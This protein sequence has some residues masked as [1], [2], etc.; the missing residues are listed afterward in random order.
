VTRPPGRDGIADP[1]PAVA[2]TLSSDQG[3]PT[4]PEGESRSE[5]RGPRSI[6]VGDSLGRYEIG[7]ELGE[8]GMATVFRAR[9]KELRRDV[10]VKVLFPHLARR[11][12]IVR[13]FHREA[14]AAAGLEHANILRIYDVG[15]A[16]GDDPPYIVME[17]IRGRT[18]L[19]EVEQ[20]GAVLAEIVAC[21]GSL[22]ADAL[23]AAHAAGII[24]RDIKPANVL[25]A[26]GGRLLLADFG[27][28]RL[29]TED[30]L[31]TKTGALLGTPAYMSPE[32]AS[33]D[34]A[35]AKS[36]LYSLGATLYQLA[37][38]SLPYT[39][40]AA[41]VMAQIATGSL[42][43]PMRKRPAVG[44]DLSR[45]IERLMTTEPE[46]RPASAATVAA[47]LRGLAAAGALGDPTE[48]LAAYFEDPAGFVLSRTPAIVTGIITAAR[49]AMTEAKYPRAMSLADRA[50]ALAPGDPQVT[51]LIETV[52]EGGRSTRRRRLLAIGALGL[53]AAGGATALGFNLRGS[54]H[55]ADARLVAM[56]DGGIALDAPIGSLID[57][58]DEPASDARVIDAPIMRIKIDAGAPV[59]L[60][61]AAVGGAASTEAGVNL[62]PVDAAV[63]VLAPDAPP[64]AATATIIVTN[65]VWCDIAIDGVAKGRERGKPIIVDAGHHTVTCTQPGINA[66]RQEVDVAAG[67]TRTVAGAML[68]TFDIT[69]DST[70]GA[71]IDGLP[72]SRGSTAKL[73]AGRHRIKVGGTEKD[74][75]IFAPCKIQENPQLDCY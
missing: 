7:D 45:I 6:R 40:P 30:S 9:D 60:R 15:G 73:K 57:A 19:E 2:D 46:Q 74:L 50:S 58:A 67:A 64:P 4:P 27:V 44:P 24:H 8:G 61:D 48:E 49:Q 36:D 59:R 68:E 32:Q 69:I 22:L 16:E 70:G 5:K 53:A 13:R 38:G 52:A 21:V 11:P 31:V 20:R 10:A 55:P 28:A 25:I 26:P 65:D 47:E 54:E 17:M 63:I 23:A 51:Q 14:R 75:S 42:V 41:R 72:Y 29:E 3:V 34:T 43:A 56:A 71:T 18:L 33:G 1:D 12:D 66:W 37:T 35:T 62:V 39:G